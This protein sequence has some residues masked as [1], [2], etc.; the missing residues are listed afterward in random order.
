MLIYYT[1]IAYIMLNYFC[2]RYTIIK[3]TRFGVLRGN[4]AK[5]VR[6]WLPQ[7]LKNPKEVVTLAEGH[8]KRLTKKIRNIDLDN[9]NDH[10]L[11]EFL[12]FGQIPRKDTNGIAHALMDRFG[13]LKGVLEATP[14]ELYAIPNMTERAAVFLP[15]ILKFAARA[16]SQAVLGKGSVRFS[17]R[18]VAEFFRDKLCFEKA[19]RL[20]IVSLT[21]GGYISEYKMVMAGDDSMI[22]FDP[23]DL[24]KAIIGT[25]CNK[26]VIV[27]NHPVGKAFPSDADK[28]STKEILK[29]FSSLNLGLVDHIIV[30]GDKYF[31]FANAGL[32]DAAKLEEVSVYDLEKEDLLYDIPFENDEVKEQSNG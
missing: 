16:R 9:L 18:I 15:T 7:R 32:M 30:A 31:S 21:R 1:L 23:L 12:L 11:L 24:V 29:K 28:H 19:E 17:P 25:Q 20:Y 26:F 22:E 6:L 13:S 5:T 14:E 3:P 2:G 4:A 27:H 8:R 10:E